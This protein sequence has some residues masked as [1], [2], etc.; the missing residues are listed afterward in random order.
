MRVNL[1]VRWVCIFLVIGVSVIESVSACTDPPIPSISSSG[2]L[3]FCSGESVTLSTSAVPG[4]SYRWKKNGNNISG[5]T[6]SSYVATTTGDYTVMVTDDGCSSTSLPAEVTVNSNPNGSLTN[7]HSICQG[8]STT[9]VANGGVSYNWSAA[10]ANNNRLTVDPTSTT[11]YSVTITGSNGCTDIESVEVTVKP[12]PLANISVAGSSTLCQGQSVNLNASTGTGYTYKWYKNNALISGETDYQ[13]TVNSSGNYHTVVTLNG[14]SKTSTPKTITVNPVPVPVVSPDATICAGQTVNMFASGGTSY[15]WSGGGPAT[16]TYDV[17]PTSTKTYTVTVTNVYGCTASADVVITVKPLPNANISLS[18]SPTLCQGQS[19]N[20]TASSGTNYTYQWHVNSTPISGETNQ[21]LNVSAGGDYHVAVTLNGCTKN[22]SVIAITVNPVP[23]AVASNDQT[24]CSGQTV[25][26]FASGGTSYQWSSGGPAA[27][28][29]DVA[30]TSTKTYTVTVTNSYGCTASDDVIIT[31]KPLPNA[32]ISLSGSSTLCQGQSINLTASSGTNYTYQWYAN[33]V[34]IPGATNQA[35]NANQSGI[36]H[37]VVTLNGCSKESLPQT[38]TV[39]PVPVPAASAD[40]TICAGQ[41]VNLFASGGTSYQ[42][43]GGGP[44]TAG[45]DVSPTSTATYNVTVTNVY[46][47]TASESVVITVKPLPN[48]NISLSGSSTI[49]QGQSVNLNASNGTGYSHQWHINNGLMGETNP[50]LTASVAGSYHVVVTLNGCAKTSA[51]V[52]ITVNP[53]PV[54]STSGDVTSCAGDT[55]TL[56]ASGGTSYQWSSGGPATATYAVAPTSTKTYTVTVTNS[57]TCTASASLTVTVK[58]L[59]NANISISSGTTLCNGQTVTLTASNGAGYSHQWHKDGNPLIGETGASYTVATGGEYYVRITLNGCA[60]ESSH[61]VFIVNE[62]PGLQVSNDTTVCSGDSVVLQAGG[63]TVYQWS[64]G[65]ATSSYSI[66]PASTKT[67]SVTVSNSY[68]CSAVGNVTVTV[69]PRPNANISS[70][71]GNTICDGQSVTLTASIGAGYSHQ[72]YKNN[73]ALNGEINPTYSVTAGGDYHVLITLDGCG[74]SS[75]HQLFTVN[76]LPVA[77]VSSDTIS[78][79]ADTVTL[80]ASGGTGYQ[81]SSGG[82]ATAIYKLAPTATKTYTVTVTNSYGCTASASVTNTVKPLPNANISISGGTTICSGQTITLNASNG[83]GYSHQ[84][85]KNN[86]ALN[87]ETNYSYTASESGDYQVVVALNG[88]YKKSALQAVTVNPVPVVQ[89]SNDTTICQ[90]ATVLLQ[91]SGGTSYQWSSGGPASANY[92]VTPASTKTYTVTVT[93][94]FGCSVSKNVTVNVIPLPQA[95]ISAAGSTTLCFGQSVTLNTASAASNTWY[96]NGSIIP[97]AASN[98]YAATTSGDY[99]AVNTSNGCA[100]ISDTIQVIVNPLPV[101]NITNDLTVCSGDS[102][103]LNAYGGTAYNWNSGQTTST[104]TV[105]PT[106][107]RTYTVAIS[108]AN[109][110]SV[111]RSVTVT[112]A[113]RPN[114]SVSLSGPATFCADRTLTMT[115]SSGTG[116]TYQWYKNNLA[117]AGATNQ[118]LIVSTSGNYLARVSVN[119]CSKNSDQISVVVNPLPSATASND[120]TICS[121]DTIAL[122]ASGGTAYQWSNGSTGNT[123]AVAPNNNSNYSVTVSNSFGCS[124]A[125][126]ISVST[127]ARPTAVASPIGTVSFCQGQSAM[128]IASSGTGYSYQWMEGVGILNGKTAQTLSVTT[129]GNYFVMITQNGCPKKSNTVQVKVNPLPVV[130]VSNDTTICS[131]NPVALSASGGSTYK[132]S[133]GSV[134]SSI[135]VSP[136]NTTSYSVTVTTSSGCSAVDGVFISVLPTPDANIVSSGSST[137]CQGQ[138]VTFDASTGPLYSY[139]WKNNGADIAGQTTSSFT[140]SQSGNY[141]VVVSAFGCP[142]TS[143]VQNVIVNSLPTAVISND[144]TICQ[145]NSVDIWAAGGTTYRWSNGRTTDS[146][147]VSPNQTSAYNVT[148]TDANGCTDTS[149]ITVTVTA[150]PNAFISYS[151]STNLCSGQS[152]T[153]NASAGSGYSHIWY[154]N[155]T[156]IVGSVNSSYIA[157]QSGSYAVQTTANGCSKISAPV[158]VTVN[159]FLNATI[160]N[161]TTICSGESVTVSA[162]G[163]SS[164]EWNTGDTTDVLTVTPSSTKTYSVTVS[165]GVNC[166]TVKSMA[167]TVKPLPNAFILVTGAVTSV[168]EGEAATMTANTGA[169]LSYQWMKDSVEITGATTGQFIAGEAGSYTV[170]VDLNGCRKVSP[171]KTLAINPLPLI[172]LSNDTSVCSGSPAVLRVSGGISYQWNTF[173]TDSVYIVATTSSRTYSVTATNSYGC[174]S[175]DTVRVTTIALPTNVSISSTS[176]TSICDGSSVLLKAGSTNGTAFQW[177]FNSDKIPGASANTYAAAQQGSYSLV[178]SLNGCSKA[179]SPIF[180]TVKPRPAT[181]EII[182]ATN[183]SLACSVEGDNYKWFRDGLTYNVGSKA[184]KANKPG[185]YKV[186]VSENNCSSDT[187]APYYFNVTGIMQNDV[188]ELAIYPN[189]SSGK[190][191]IELPKSSGKEMRVSILNT[192]GQVV[193]TRD[194]DTSISGSGSLAVDISDLVSGIYFVNIRSGDRMLAGRIVVSR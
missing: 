129:P 107:T 48:A 153:L 99:F 30:P 65:P 124:V 136:N 67:Y 131:G 106:S 84:W 189:P 38:I 183:D 44:A 191:R 53:V 155:G 122:Y 33:S 74:K 186:Y 89:V 175:S 172:S 169:G 164:Y 192:L 31:V 110:C 19:I 90:E 86:V 52:V 78:C 45:Y 24:I 58:P 61:H 115:A 1:L 133:T 20:L 137:L 81:W 162:T 55:L 66:A 21:A 120:T 87:G 111:S 148:V 12:L 96:R 130:S 75:A 10:G 180:V 185:V 177:Q 174:E 15:Q 64:G 182:R 92:S 51:P 71:G 184:I 118:Q 108:D 166:S 70:S 140:A 76:P 178:V 34:L 113:A 39:N 85:Y 109:S 91:A 179:S 104:I 59:P 158:T 181:P 157:S 98:S 17:A 69:K 32:N 126:S 42:W 168:C 14:C 112:V 62:L 117:V 102:A 8:A 103:M 43:S 132:W 23:V 190:F 68:G 188:S 49:C 82:P 35:L 141:S 128:L 105:A 27:A 77:Q 41:T 97:G 47:C 160:S 149:R 119:G 4:Y 142:K 116:Y 2:P 167:V 60:R 147:T 37:V 7:D 63:G 121:G 36:Y 143:A 171:E 151:S 88:C 83:T 93:N 94:S 138:S 72:W 161:D 127:I 159:T 13:L 46:G 9:L 26:L 123:I 29:Y 194:L 146:I 6:N 25:S 176:S 73:L 154:N 139:Q 187:S 144:T 11:T 57:Y 54:P 18:G 150:L 16:A 22:S 173:A 114:A 95:W 165:N 163:G 80:R 135:T 50:T 56:Q 79:A 5:A 3:T 125:E 134:N 100:D 101:V 28:N 193:S 156:E 145:T 40:E 170:E 152:V